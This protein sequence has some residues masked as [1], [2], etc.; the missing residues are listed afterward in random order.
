MKGRNTGVTVDSNDDD[1]SVDVDEGR[2]NVAASS[3]ERCH[4]ENAKDSGIKNRL[5]EIA[6]F[7]LKSTLK[8]RW[9]L[10]S[11]A[12]IQIEVQ[13][14]CPPLWINLVL[15][16]MTKVW[17]SDAVSTQP[18]LNQGA[19]SLMERRLC[20][21]EKKDLKLNF[22]KDTV[23]TS[24]SHPAGNRNASKRRKVKSAVLVLIPYLTPFLSSLF[25]PFIN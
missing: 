12:A 22:Q 11:L 1:D 23:L 7:H 13:P 15:P 24:E 4:C 16:H 5:T 20:F 3:V 19:A 6:V 2:R 10:P 9:N 14:E 25:R 8:F 21:Q 18:K 17:T